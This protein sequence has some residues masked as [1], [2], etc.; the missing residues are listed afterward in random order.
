MSYDRG[1]ESSAAFRA[2]L[3]HFNLSRQD[4]ALAASV[5]LLT[6]WKIEQGLPVREADALSV[7]AG[8]YHLTGE[9]FPA[10]IPVI[11]AGILLMTQASQTGNTP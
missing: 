10:L 6:V 8:L 1:A 11:P 7:C 5:R 4:V 3:H 9:A 2:Y